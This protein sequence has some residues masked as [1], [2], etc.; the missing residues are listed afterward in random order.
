MSLSRLLCK[1]QRI[2]QL[3]QKLKELFLLEV[4][5]KIARKT[6]FIQRESKFNAETFVSLCT[7]SNDDLCIN[8]LSQ[9][10]CKLAANNDIT[11]SAEGLNERFNEKS[12]NFL[13]EILS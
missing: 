10:C 13:K 7:F 12:V 11:I 1:L 8:S 6:K 4:I 2:K 5:Q 9:L 3:I